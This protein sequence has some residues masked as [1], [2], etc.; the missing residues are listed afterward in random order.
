MIKEFS[1]QDENNKG[2]IKKEQI[3]I[4]DW[5]FFFYN[6]RLAKDF[7]VGKYEYTR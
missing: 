7:V 5:G 1:E 3:N 6:S 2:V 4:K